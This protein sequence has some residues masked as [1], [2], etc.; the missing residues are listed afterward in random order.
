MKLLNINLLLLTLI[1]LF[2]CNKS[3][4]SSESEFSSEPE[5]AQREL[6]SCLFYDY[7]DYGV[8]HNNI[9]HEILANVTFSN[10]ALNNESIAIEEILAQYVDPSM[11]EPYPNYIDRTSVENAEV[12]PAIKFYLLDMHDWIFA[13]GE[14]ED[15]IE[16]Y[17]VNGLMTFLCNLSDNIQDDTSLSATD[18]EVLMK[19]IGLLYMSFKLWSTEDMGGEFAFVSINISGLVND[20]ILSP[21]KTPCA[22]AVGVTAWSDAWGGFWGAVKGGLGGPV[23]AG[24]GA[25][26]G[27]DV[28][29]TGAAAANASNFKDC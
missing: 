16:E 18:K 23:G 5:V 12:S 21:R 28:A 11:F 22:C 13:F 7:I 9:V 25:A 6:S 8:E 14:S 1:I 20:D 4:V 19:S 2:S 27:A 24:A 29:S 26:Y 15:Y 3:E 17:T 10:E